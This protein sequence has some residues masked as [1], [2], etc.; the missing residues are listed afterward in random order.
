MENSHGFYRDALREGTALN[1]FT[2]SF[3]D[4]LNVEL[5]KEDAKID[6]SPKGMKIR[7]RDWARTILG[8]A[9]TIAMMGP[10]IL[11]EEPDLLKY[12]WQFDQDQVSFTIGSPRFLIRKQY[13]NREK[14][15]RAFEKVYKDRETKQ[16]DAIWWIPGRQRMLA[17]AG[18]TSDYDVG[19]STLPV[20][21][22]CV[23]EN[24]SRWL[25]STDFRLQTNSNPAAFWLL[26]HIVT[27]PGLADRIRKSIAPAFD[28]E[29]KV[30]NLGLVVNDPLLRS[31]FNETLRLY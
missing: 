20:W 2:A 8:T 9:S 13:A 28:I 12:N 10:Q 7:L 21:N 15:I 17:E 1:E 22:A 25:D 16:H 26:L 6:A 4:C 24:V 23:S 19:A 11:E 29:G 14:L 31:T 27:I 30:T 3:L 5:A 18:M